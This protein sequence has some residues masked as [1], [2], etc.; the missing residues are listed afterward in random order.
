MSTTYETGHAKNVASF[1]TLISFCKAYGAT[2]NPGKAALSV[3]SL[4]TLLQQAQASLEQL[5]TAESM[6]NTATNKRGQ[7][8]KPLKSLST[9]IINALDATDASAEVVKDARTINRKLQGK[10]AVAV[11]KTQPADAAQTASPK[12]I[13][14]SQLSFDQQVEHF[15]KLVVLL[16]SETSYTPNETELQVAT[17]Q[18]RLTDLR[19]ANSSVVDTY[20]GLNK[21]R[22]ERD[23]VFYTAL[24]GMVPVALDVKKYVKS[25]YG[26][27]SPEYKQVA[28]LEF[29]NINP[30]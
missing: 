18:Q 5:K 12:V 13:S 15:A 17:N 24:S 19:N 4:T 26:A 7:A 29:K 1:E 23:R 27:A 28:G 3:A 21:A 25:I 11:D 10:R 8:F 6:F 20:T 16:S 14:A 9:K 22:L 2:Y 30:R